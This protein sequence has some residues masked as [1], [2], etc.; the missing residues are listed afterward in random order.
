MGTE[1]FMEEIRA[2]GGTL[3]RKNWKAPKSGNGEVSKVLH[4]ADDFMG[5]EN[6]RLPQ[7][8]PAPAPEPRE[9]SPISVLAEEANAQMDRSGWTLDEG[10]KRVEVVFSSK[11]A[12]TEFRKALNPNEIRGKVG[13]RKTK[14]WKTYSVVFQPHS[15][16]DRAA[17]LKQYKPEKPYY[18]DINKDLSEDLEEEKGPY[19]ARNLIRASKSLDQ[20]SR[21][22]AH[23]KMKDAAYSIQDALGEL[24]YAFPDFG[25]DGKLL[26]PL[27]KAFL[28]AEKHLEHVVEAVEK[29]KNADTAFRMGSQMARETPLQAMQ[30][31]LYGTILLAKKTKNRRL[32][33]ALGKAYQ[34]V[35]EEVEKAAA[36]A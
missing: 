26:R 15:F 36:G 11:T 12:A 2:L 30:Y 24:A 4:E 31:G 28:G 32:L 23:N 34:I 3:G 35:E 8:E 22:V 1:K 9:Q 21:F 27:K 33:T 16:A 10:E 7:R 14:G 6:W 13:V 25:V 17:F 29:L 18:R 19:T 5:R 20:A